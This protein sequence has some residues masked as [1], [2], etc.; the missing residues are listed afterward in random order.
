MSANV[1][2]STQEKNPKKA[3]SRTTLVVIVAAFPVL[4][5]TLL[6]IQAELSPYL[7]ALPGWVFA[8]LNGGIMATA[9]LSAI[10]T[11]I[12]ALPAVNNW[13]RQFVPALAPDSA[14]PARMDS[15]YPL[16]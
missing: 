2:Q 16:G 10:F 9:V 3:I 6:I 7:S 12:M 5:A 8:I 13:L 1:A 11:K 15:S 14:P 4:N